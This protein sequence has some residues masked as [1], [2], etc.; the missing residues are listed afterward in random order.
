MLTRLV[1]NILERPLAIESSPSEPRDAI[2]VL[3]APLAKDGALTHVLAERVAAAAQL[4]RAGGAA[5]VAVSG[6]ITHGAPRAEADAL[7]EGLRAAGVPD[8]IVERASMTTA[9]NARLCAELLAP[10]G[11]HRVWIVTQPFHGKRAALLFRRAGFDARVWHIADSLQY[12]DRKRALKW[13]A[14]E[15]ASWG[16]L[17]VRR[18]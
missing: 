15:W 3:G 6:G 9:Q 18:R 16:A 11:V 4:Y 10:R 17:L 2:I 14:R 12:R 8:V 5:L 7:A 1:A 13:L